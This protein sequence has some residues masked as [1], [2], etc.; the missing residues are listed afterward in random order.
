MKFS[1]ELCIYQSA[2]DLFSS[3]MHLAL[4]CFANGQLSTALKLLYRARY[5]M[6]LVSGEDHP[7]MALLDVSADLNLSRLINQDNVLNTC[8][9]YR[10][11]TTCQSCI[12][13]P[14]QSN[15]GLVL[16]GVMEYDLSLRFLENA[17]TINTKYHGARSLK[18]A[19]RYI[20][21]LSVSSES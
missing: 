19:L 1:P 3:Q 6:L 20:R 5:L 2:C 8:I 18:V 16:H 17:L 11:T 14:P 4:Y 7:E 15:I 9:L 21:S 10:N 12:L 13:S